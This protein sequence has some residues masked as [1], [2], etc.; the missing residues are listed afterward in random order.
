M[1]D[2]FLTI[3]RFWPSYTASVSKRSS[4]GPS[5]FYRSVSQQPYPIKNPRFFKR[6]ITLRPQILIGEF[7]I[8]YVKYA[9]L[10]GA[11]FG[12]LRFLISWNLSKWQLE[13]LILNPKITIISKQLAQFW[14]YQKSETTKRC[15]GW[16]C[17][18]H[19][20]NTKLLD[21]YSWT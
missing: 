7:S 20:P 9:A 4:F 14:R 21:E 1:I 18:F 12:C 19:V 13:N 6:T 2:L 5:R 15:A 8:W 11:S 10:H 17:I 3:R 16:S